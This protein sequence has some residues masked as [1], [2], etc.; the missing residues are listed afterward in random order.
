ML[1]LTRALMVV[2]GAA[3]FGG[4][5]LLLTQFEDE[6]SQVPAA[7]KLDYRALS[8]QQISDQL[9]PPQ[10]GMGVKQFVGWTLPAP[11]GTRVLRVTCQSY[12]EPSDRPASVTYLF[13]RD[14]HRMP[15]RSKVLLDV[16]PAVKASTLPLGSAP[17]SAGP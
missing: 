7:W 2:A 14:R 11:D 9:G 10:E 17:P 13:H 8:I 16:Q 1:M 15:V 6:A 4:V 12:C 5:P 3:F